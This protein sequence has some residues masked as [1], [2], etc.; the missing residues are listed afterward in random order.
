MEAMRVLPPAPRLQVT[1]AV[2]L[3]E[4]RRKEEAALMTYGWI[5]KN[6]GVVRLP[7]GRAIDLIVERGLPPGKPV[8]ASK[9]QSGGGKSR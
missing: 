1:T 9:P 7:I 6:A 8:P 4:L 2:D 5:D 3:A